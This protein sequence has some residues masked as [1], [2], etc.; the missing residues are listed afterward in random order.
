MISI[1]KTQLHLVHVDRL[2]H[3]KIPLHLFAATIAK[4]FR[5]ALNPPA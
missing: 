1:S 5:R 3:P 2:I 4:I